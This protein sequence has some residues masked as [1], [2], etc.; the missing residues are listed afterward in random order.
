M[1]GSDLDASISEH[2]I[3]QKGLFVVPDLALDPRFEN[4]RYVAGPPYLRFYAGA[5]LMS[6]E[7]VPIGTL[8]V[9][10]HTPRQ[11]SKAQG[12]ALSI[13]ARQ[14]MTTLELRLSQKRLQS[15]IES[16]SDA[17][18]TLDHEFRVLSMNDRAEQL[19]GQ[20]NK[21]LRHAI[22]EAWESGA[23]SSFVQ[24]LRHVATELVPVCFET[25]S[26]RSDAWFEVRAFPAPDG[27]TVTLSDIT[28]RREK[29]EQLRTLETC[30]SRLNDIVI[31]TGTE[32]LEEPGPRILFVNDAFLKLTGYTRE[33][34]V[35]R[36][37]RFL[38]STD[39][40]G[41]AECRIEAALKARR[42]VREEFVSR[43]KTGEK[44][45]LDLEIAPI[46]DTR[47]R[48]TNLVFIG[49]D[50]TERKLAEERL[51]E[52]Q[53]RWRDILDSMIA[54]V[55]LFSTDG[56]VL[57]VNRAPLEAAGLHREDVLGKPFAD[58]YW[59]KH[60]PSAREELRA[61]LL[62]VADGETVR[63]EFKVQVAGGRLITLDAIFCPLRD[64]T[65]KVTHLAGSA[66]DITKRKGAEEARRESELKFRQLAENI[67]EVFWVADPAEQRVLYV[68]PAFEAI[69][70]REPKSLYS[71]PYAWLE[72]IHP[73]DQGRVRDAFMA[74]RADGSYDEEY[75][76]VRPD[77]TLRWIHDRAFP[78]KDS[79]G[80]YYRLVGVA[81]DISKRKQA[82]ERLRE[83]ATLL[84]KAHDAIVVCDL[85]QRIIFWNRGAE[86]LYGWPAEEA[87]GKMVADLMFPD[88]SVFQGATRSTLANGEWAGELEQQTRDGSTVTVEGRWTAVRDEHGN[89]KSILT[90]NTDI[91]ERKKLEEQFFRAQRM[92][93]IGT[94]AG[95][96]AHDLNNVL[97][98]IM[99]SIDLL[100]SYSPEPRAQQVLEMIGVSTRRGA[101]MVDQVLTFARGVEGRRTKV[102]LGLVALE[103]V[104][105]AEETFPKNINIEIDANTDLEPLRADSTQLHQVLLNLLVNARDAMREGGRLAVRVTNIRGDGNP[106]IPIMDAHPRAYVCI[107]VED[108]GSGMSKDTVEK[109][110]EP[111][112]TTKEVGSGT[113]L[114]LSTSLAIVK[115]YGGFIKVHS[116]EGR[117][118]RFS[119]FL[120]AAEGAP[121]DSSWWMAPGLPRGKGETVLVVDDEETI[122]EITQRTLEA[123]GYTVL[124]AADGEEAVALYARSSGTID[125]VI[126]DMMMPR[127]DGPALVQFLRLVSPNARIIGVSG[128]PN[129]HLM[130]R[131]T[132]A[133]MKHFLR[134]PFTTGEILR[135]LQEVLALVQQP[136][137]RPGCKIRL[138]G[139]EQNSPIEQLPPHDGRTQDHH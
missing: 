100:K 99:M 84:D 38:A 51:G 4:N 124:P 119:V 44:L 20:C 62:R 130:A 57:E 3:R 30:V 67:S 27:L 127:M 25:Y 5:R 64:A 49:R 12:E 46:S 39:T 107:E 110:F 97:A 28:R 116:E 6:G 75:R 35:G 69:W 70:G 53:A 120:P 86:R 96:I 74:G 98:P 19:L 13:L 77:G 54:F 16:I 111:F 114:G 24:H 32:L 65:G 121:D 60:S 113:G 112:F 26:S 129:Q 63:G 43:T 23:D 37:P 22:W 101:D 34:A 115:S 109:I 18:V 42:P 17:F 131:C 61:V 87:L 47:G 45:W 52:T 40:P 92:E 59:W 135:A 108:N 106:E 118:S 68:S 83:Q 128:A 122:R 41:P 71:S 33:E 56:V 82:E 66:V 85:E 7:G 132:E 102:D 9:L 73:E 48:L 89:T 1:R 21:V 93:S 76:I 117:G 72:S 95:G 29:E 58:S 50:I 126:A 10:D 125:V 138:Y 105:I 78:V 123:F 80:E 137:Q 55:G 90:I 88:L 91:T 133:G 15:T 14:V 136:V 79:S 139:S 81:E 134:K 2:A 104:K 8:C 31:I 94:L 103:V 36:S 11:L